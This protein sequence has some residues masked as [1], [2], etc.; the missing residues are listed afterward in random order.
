MM[1]E[2]RFPERTMPIIIADRQTATLLQAAH[3]PEE[4]R[5]ADGHV[6]GQFIP[7][8]KPKMT[9]PELG[10]TDEELERREKDPNAKWYSADEVMA[11]LA[12]LRRKS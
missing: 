6:L 12:E 5:T 3:G 7:A 10:I 8:A 1:G 2:T 9:F 4:V 11:R